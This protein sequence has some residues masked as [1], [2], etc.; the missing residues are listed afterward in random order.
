MA[1]DLFFQRI[2]DT[3]PRVGQNTRTWNGHKHSLLA[4]PTIDEHWYHFS[5]GE[6]L[7]QE[8][9]LPSAESVA[10]ATQNFN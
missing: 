5:G 7:F 8:R 4:R 3:Q 6:A 1:I 9:Q 10:L 2:Q